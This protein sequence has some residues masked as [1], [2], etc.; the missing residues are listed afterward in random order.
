MAAPP[1]AAH[2]GG[3][4]MKTHILKTKQLYF[5]RQLGTRQQKQVKTQE[6]IPGGLM[7][8]PGTQN[9]SRYLD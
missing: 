9:F 8:F 4:E 3:E 1:A 7:P 2:H 6:L 5:V